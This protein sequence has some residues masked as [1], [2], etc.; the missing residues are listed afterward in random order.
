M[1]QSNIPTGFTVWQNGVTASNNLATFTLPIKSGLASSIGYGDPVCF[2]GAYPS[3][4]LGGIPSGG[5]R[6]A[7]TVTDLAA[8]TVPPIV[9]IFVGCKYAPSG[10]GSTQTINFKSWVGGTTT[11]NGQDAEAEVVIDPNQIFS[12]MCSSSIGVGNNYFGL[13]AAGGIGSNGYLGLGIT[14]QAGVGSQFPNNVIY[15]DGAL[16][17]QNPTGVSSTGYSG[18]YLDIGGGGGGATGVGVTASRSQVVILGLE[19]TLN[20]Y[21]NF[22]QY[23]MPNMYATKPG[24][25]NSLSPAVVTPGSFNRVLVRINFHRFNGA[26]VA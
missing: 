14:G 22:N 3:N 7:T 13:S 23:T 5:I 8:A 24:I 20:N 11:S 18:V 15:P 16:L 10:S 25:D 21:A 9:G 6:A 17:Q 1:I 4:G 19:P 12:I 26:T 2:D